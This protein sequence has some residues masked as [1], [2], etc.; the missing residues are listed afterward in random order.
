MKR[1]LK[2]QS[3]LWNNEAHFKHS[4]KKHTS[5]QQGS[6]ERTFEQRSALRNE[7]MYFGI[8]KDPLSIKNCMAH[9]R[10]LNILSTWCTYEAQSLK[11]H[12]K[13]LKNEAFFLP[14]EHI[15]HSLILKPL[16]TWHNHE[17]WILHLSAIRLEEL[18][19][20][21]SSWAHKII[22][23]DRSLTPSS[24]QCVPLCPPFLIERMSA[25]WTN[26][27]FLLHASTV[28][29]VPSL[30]LL[31]TWVHLEGL[32]PNPFIPLVCTLGPSL[33]SLSAWVHLEPTYDS[34][35]CFGPTPLSSLS[36]LSTQ[37]HLEGLLWALMS[38]TI[39]S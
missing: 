16:S 17:A 11:A 1:T 13:F 23:K 2:Q 38:L 24:P 4:V 20:P 25:P 32:K 37:A 9:S 19:P 8:M 12:D 6:F 35:S 34:P 29:P 14:F 5:K 36:L 10:I 3:T 7:E 26:E 30:L 31:S 15:E 22:A 21:S 28:H 33:A 27:C 39:P 18:L